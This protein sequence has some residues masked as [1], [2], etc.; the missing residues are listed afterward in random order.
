MCLCPFPTYSPPGWWWEAC[1]MHSSSGC[2]LTQPALGW[3]L[4][5]TGGGVAIFRHLGLEVKL[6]CHGWHLTS[7]TVHNCISS[8][9]EN[10]ICIT[11]FPALIKSGFA[12][13]FL[14][15][16][17]ACLLHEHPVQPNKNKHPTSSLP[18]SAP[19]ALPLTVHTNHL[20]QYM[21]Q[22]CQCQCGY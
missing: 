6:W 18:P 21:V 12:C 19:S 7:T 17:F 22:N 4:K 11:A 5:F 10:W 1:I 9:D 16:H 15:C 3:Q 2:G 20:T 8:F 14:M 13:F